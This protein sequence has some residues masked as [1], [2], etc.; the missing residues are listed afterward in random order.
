MALGGALWLQQT[1]PPLP[2]PNSHGVDPR[3]AGDGAYG[4]ESIIVVYGHDLG[5][6]LVR[7]MNYCITIVE[8]RWDFS[9]FV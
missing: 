9:T 6:A 1:V 4:E 7:V 2:G 8:N 3:Q 5:V